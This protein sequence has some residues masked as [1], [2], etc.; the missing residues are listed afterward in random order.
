[1]E[2][3]LQCSEDMP[4]V[5]IVRKIPEGHAARVQ[6]D[7]I[8]PIRAFDLEREEK[9]DDE[10]EEEDDYVRDHPNGGLK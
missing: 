5:E 4:G 3:L 1:M 9:G 2:T 8:S 10:D 7:I 6:E